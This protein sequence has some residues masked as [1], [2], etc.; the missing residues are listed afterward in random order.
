VRGNIEGLSG[1]G[2]GHRHQGMTGFTYTID[3]AGARVTSSCPR[4]VA[5]HRLLDDSADGG[6]V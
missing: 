5:H 3:E 1:D 4:V 6:C 2:D